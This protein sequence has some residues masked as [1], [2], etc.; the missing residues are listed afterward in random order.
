[1]EFPNSG[2]PVASSHNVD[3]FLKQKFHC[4]M[5][6]HQDM[7]LYREKKNNQLTFSENIRI[8][9][10]KSAIRFSSSYAELLL[11]SCHLVF[12]S[13]QLFQDPRKNHA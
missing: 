2:T 11:V 4:K 13:R 9:F 12:L 6:G 7:S 1:M 10:G 5:K 8:F 3:C